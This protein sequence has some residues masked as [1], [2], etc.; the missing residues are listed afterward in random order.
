M[1]TRCIWSA[2]LLAFAL[3]LPPSGTA[4][5][6]DD[7]IV[8]IKSAYSMPE[9][10]KRIKKDVAD[11]GIMFFSEIDQSKLAADAG[12][13]LRPSTLIVFGNPP[14]GTLFLTSD[15]SAGLDWPVRVLV[16]QDE[17]GD[18]WVNYT[19]FMWIARRHGITDRDEAFKKASEVIA[20]ITSTV[21]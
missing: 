3:L 4:R 17:K 8:R 11:K 10:I 15:P 2:A 6:E 19:D 13:T 21:Q 7:G 16:Y 14:L 18:V 12:V 9:T 1:F 5:A 20:S